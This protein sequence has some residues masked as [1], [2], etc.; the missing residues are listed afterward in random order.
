MT[1]SQPMSQAWPG[2]VM[3]DNFTN[4]VDGLVADQHL[5][6]TAVFGLELQ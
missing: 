5:R 2:I 4:S 3:S 1:R 6:L